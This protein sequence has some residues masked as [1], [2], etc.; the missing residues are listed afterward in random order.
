MDYS[1]SL[2]GFPGLDVN[3]GLFNEILNTHLWEKYI[4]LS[5]YGI[6]LLIICSPKMLKDAVRIRLISNGT[7]EI[8]L[9]KSVTQPFSFQTKIS[10]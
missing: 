2:V 6:Q 1:V 7:T 5:I 9:C 4:E 10:Q 8:T 3:R